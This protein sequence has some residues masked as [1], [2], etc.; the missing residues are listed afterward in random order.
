MTS[1]TLPQAMAAAAAAN[2]TR[3][4]VVDRSDQVTYAEL[5]RRIAALA[6]ALC[7]R[8]I[9]TGD[10]VAMMLVNSLDFVVTYFAIASL[11]AIVVPMNE[12]Y[13]R[14]ELLYFL[15]EPDASLL[16]TS[17][18]FAELAETVLGGYQGGCEAVYI[19]DHRNAD[20]G[21]AAS[22]DDVAVDPS[23]PVMYQYSSG[24]TGRPKRIA[25]DH[26]NVLFELDSLVRTLGLTNRDR[27]IGVAPFSHVNG[28]MRTMMA[29]LYAGATLFPLPRFD[30]Q[31]VVETIERN[32]ITVFIA[33]PFM[34]SVLAQSRFAS[35]P[36]L[37][38]L[39]LCVS[40]SAPMPVPHNRMFKERF[41]HYVRQLYGSTETGT[42]S[43]NLSDDIVDTLESVGL[44]IRGVS[45]RAFA[46]DGSEAAPD[47]MGELA[48]AS[49]AAI[50]EYVGREDINREA[51]RDG[52]FFTGDVGRIDER[53]HIYLIGRK[54]FF[55]NKGGFKIDPRE[56]QELIE[57]HPRVLEAAVLGIPSAF[58]DDKV[59]AVVVRDGECSEQDIVDHCRGRIA[60]FKIPSII[61]FRDSLPKSPTGK[62]RWEMLR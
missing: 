23:L 39:R 10:R 16:V 11:G 28:M 8:D 45:V 31:A 5:T 36:D 40:A 25:R 4:A 50:R 43:V 51:F 17:R 34:F 57:S 24:T 46:D 27:F 49:P 60:D 53:G 61:E 59:K 41:G 15:A 29:C 9:G 48:V 47:G 54:K 20:R 21:D 18:D 33:V 55:I 32:G 7:H 38:S 30:R 58:G 56:I 37:S 12:H 19:D 42:I 52:Y 62:L 2:A 6:R 14:D 1:T 44:P 3:L 13:Q 35:P 26:A 22:L